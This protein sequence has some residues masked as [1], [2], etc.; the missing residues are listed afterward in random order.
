MYNWR[1]SINENFVM[2]NCLFFLSIVFGSAGAG[3]ESGWVAVSPSQ[4]TIHR[5][6]EEDRAIWVVFAKD[7][8]SERVLIRFPE[9]PSYQK[10]QGRFKA[11]V[12]Q[13]GS[14]EL[15]LLVE[16]K[17]NPS[18]MEQQTIRYAAYFDP[19]TGFWVREKHIETGS[20]Q[21]VLRVVN[22]SENSSIFQQFANSF[23]VEPS[24]VFNR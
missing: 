9:D 11:Y 19:Q 14:G 18:P 21:Y 8:G 3:V 12:S 17:K 23:E 15:T 22:P 16:E 1:V 6:E 24:S 5:L 2:L 10:Q 13:L 4:K 20:N 7:F